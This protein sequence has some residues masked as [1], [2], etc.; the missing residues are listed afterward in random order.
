MGE[1]FDAED[2]PEVWTLA[3][4]LEEPRI[5]LKAEMEDGCPKDMLEA[6]EELQVA[7]GDLKGM[8]VEEAHRS[9]R[10]D[11][12]DV[13][14]HVGYSV[15]EI[16]AA[17]D[18][19]NRRGQRWVHQ[20]RDVEVLREDSG[21]HDITLVEAVAKAMAT[22]HS[23]TDLSPGLQELSEVI[24]AVDSNLAMTCTLLNDKIKALERK[25]VTL[26]RT[27]PSLSALSMSMP[28]ND[29]HKD[30]V[31]TLGD[32]LNKNDEL[33]RENSLLT[34]RVEGLAAD[35][36]AQGGVVLGK[37]A[38]TSELQLLQVCMKECPKGNLFAAFVHPM[39]IFCFDPAYV[40]LLGGWE[41]LTKAMEKSGNYPVT[42]RKVVASYNAHHSHWFSKGKMVVAGKTLPAFSSKEKWQGTGGMDGRQVKIKLSLDTLADGVRTVIQDKFPAG[43]QLRKLALRMLEHTLAWFSTVFKHLDAKF[44]H[45]TQVSISEE[46]TLILLSEEVIIMFDRFHAI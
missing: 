14:M 45:L 24:A 29:A 39:V 38:F 35:I 31:T 10:S 22:A 28:I 21:C 42:D 9:S 33:R 26:S 32:M 2:P 23:S 13:L 1:G 7:F 46:E 6:V 17:I 20:S 41:T 44:V 16:V 43:S 4:D 12:L 30:F 15:T 27:S 8:V 25:Q 37:H 36:T 3:G 5:T 34:Q 11:A 19:I 40:P 18:Q